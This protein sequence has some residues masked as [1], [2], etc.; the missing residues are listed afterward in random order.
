MSPAEAERP[1]PARIAKRELVRILRQIIPVVG[2]ELADEGRAAERFC[3]RFLIVDTDLD[4]L[5]QLLVCSRCSRKLT[6]I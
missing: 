3:H 1:H 4:R 2:V 5:R 6:A